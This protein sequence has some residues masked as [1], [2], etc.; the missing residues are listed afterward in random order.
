MLDKGL[1][2]KPSKDLTKP[3]QNALLAKRVYKIDMHFKGFDTQM[4]STQIE[5]ASKLEA[6][7]Q[8]AYAIY[9]TS[10]KHLS[11]FI[12]YEI[13]KIII[14]YGHDWFKESTQK[15]DLF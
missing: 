9:I 12:F 1:F 3:I 4:L 14:I 5:A 11:Y 15:R 13:L 2:P 7:V 6:I 8:R 10:L